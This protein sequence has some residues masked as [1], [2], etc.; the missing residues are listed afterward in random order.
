MRPSDPDSCHS[1]RP[2]NCC[3]TLTFHLFADFILNTGHSFRIQCP[4][5][6]LS[7]PPP[8]LSLCVAYNVLLRTRTRKIIPKS[9]F[10]EKEATA[11]Q[12][13]LF[14]LCV[15]WGNPGPSLA[16]FRLVFP[17]SH[18]PVISRSSVPTQPS[19]LDN[20]VWEPVSFV[21]SVDN[22]PITLDRRTIVRP[23][24]LG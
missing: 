6:F 5:T 8:S 7:F 20:I 21:T 2:R 22:L 14:R 11:A 19:M 13:L 15:F 1:F 24:Q 10:T 3:R 18:V 12:F 23:R 9:F 16:H 4:W 17:F